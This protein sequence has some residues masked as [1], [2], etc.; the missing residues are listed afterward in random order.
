MLRS[1]PSQIMESHS[2]YVIRNSSLL[3]ND[4]LLV[5]GAGGSGNTLLGNHY[6]YKKSV[7]KN[8]KKPN[9]SSTIEVSDGVGTATAIIQRDIYDEMVLNDQ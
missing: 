8:L 4:P 3:I 1:L 5:V 2:K 7:K 9:A 6:G